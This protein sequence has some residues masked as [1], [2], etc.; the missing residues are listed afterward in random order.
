MDQAW[1]LE[2]EFWQ[3]G[4]SGRVADYYARVLASDG[5]VVVPG[6]VLGRDDLLDQW[7]DRAAWKDFSLTEPQIV[8]VNGETA[9]LTYHISATQIG[10][11]PYRA[12][13]SSIYTW[14][15]HGWALA[16]RQHTP[17]PEPTAA[18]DPA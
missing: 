9:A 1:Q 7:R 5:F 15:A 2:E 16:F 8:L 3:A 11:E 6:R 13:V 14:V 4:T 12:R 17:D 18:A 10:G